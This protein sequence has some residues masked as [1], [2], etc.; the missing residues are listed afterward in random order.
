MNSLARSVFFI[1]IFAAL[2]LFAA[3][4]QSP[5]PI[6]VQAASATTSAPASAVAVP[7]SSASLQAAIK[8]L[9]EARAANS[10]TLKK[11]EAVLEQLD[12][13]QKNAAQL[14]IFAHRTG[15]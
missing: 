1:S 8:S 15:G 11:Q 10:E 3:K 13:M 14:K 7:D 5:K 2:S 12:E 4:A 6:V 9:Q